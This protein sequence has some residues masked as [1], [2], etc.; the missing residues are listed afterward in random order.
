MQAKW[1][2]WMFKLLIVLYLEKKNSY[3][4]TVAFIVALKNKV[5]HKARLWQLNGMKLQRK[6]IINVFSFID[7]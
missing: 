2:N 4:S 5:Y 6:S 7:K 1:E 3:D